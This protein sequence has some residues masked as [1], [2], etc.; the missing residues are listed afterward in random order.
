MTATARHPRLREA[1]RRRIAEQHFAD[2]NA[3]DCHELPVTPFAQAIQM[4]VMAG[5]HFVTVVGARGF[6]PPTS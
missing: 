4:G 5:V 6:E 2:A 3:T 1:E